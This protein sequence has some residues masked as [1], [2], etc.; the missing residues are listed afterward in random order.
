MKKFVDAVIVLFLAFILV[1]CG[2]DKGE[3]QGDSCNAKDWGITLTVRDVS[4]TGLTLIC[5]QSGG[6]AEGSLETGSAY[7]IEKYENGNWVELETQLEQATWDMMAHLIPS[8]SSVEWTIDWSYLY[9]EL[10]EGR[11]RICK[12]IADFKG[13]GDSES[14]FY[15]AEFEI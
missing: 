8:D 14:Q 6:I 11:Y 3:V 15:C 12:S 4:T 9:G 13:S 10:G 1:A 5:T 2:A 7:W